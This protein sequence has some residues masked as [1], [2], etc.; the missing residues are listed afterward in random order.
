M[1]TEEKILTL[2][3]NPL[4]TDYALATMTDGRL[5]PANVTRYRKRLEEERD[6]GK[7]FEGMKKKTELILLEIA[8]EVERVQPK[9]KKDVRKMVHDYVNNQRRKQ[10]SE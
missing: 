10:I 1:R 2:L 7:V 8:E 6:A 4:L 9:T 3:K 5:Y